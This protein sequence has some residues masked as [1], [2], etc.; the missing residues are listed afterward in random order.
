[1][2]REYELVMNKYNFYEVKE[3]IIPNVGMENA[4]FISINFH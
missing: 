3:T 4:N 1:M 2:A